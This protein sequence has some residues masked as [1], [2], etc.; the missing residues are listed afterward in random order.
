MALHRLF[1]DVQRLRDR[2]VAEPWLKSARTSDS[3]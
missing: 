2:T 1:A 3:R